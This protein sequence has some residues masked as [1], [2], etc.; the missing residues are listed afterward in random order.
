MA[1]EI[2]SSESAS[3]ASVM[4]GSVVGTS[5]RRRR[6]SDDVGLNADVG[7]GGELWVRF[8]C[9]GAGTRNSK[10]LEEDIAIVYLRVAVRSGAV[11][12]SWW[13]LWGR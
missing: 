1:S 10:G 11:E 5:E 9:G 13:I 2:S 7:V 12:G 4:S 6:L 8:G 3:V